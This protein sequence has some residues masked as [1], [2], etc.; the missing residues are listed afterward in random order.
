M[1]LR[2]SVA[3][4]VRPYRRHGRAPRSGVGLPRSR[5]GGE[6]FQCDEAFVASA[7]AEAHR[8][9]DLV[10]GQPSETSVLD[11]GCGAGRLAIGLL[12][13]GTVPASYVGVDVQKDHV[14]WC[15]RQI[16][17]SNGHFSFHLLDAQNERYNPSG[18]APRSLPFEDDQFT[19][20]YAY[21]VFSHMRSNDVSKYL[22]EAHRV[23]RPGG[24]ALITAFVETGCPA[25]EEN[26]AGYGPWDTWDGPLHCVRFSVNFIAELI[27]A[28][29]MKWIGYRHGSDTDGQSLIVL[30]NT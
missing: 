16:S 21:S 18:A 15:R 14:A 9:F 24:I 11:F 30:S 7:V 3:S 2:D 19:A 12:E 5:Q 22:A 23:L 10:P 1:F 6:H 20:F 26:P 28:A 25:E 29:E 8:L 4:I 27:T 13:A 17:R